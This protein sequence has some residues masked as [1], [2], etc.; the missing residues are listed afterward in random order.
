MNNSQKLF[1]RATYR[2]KAKTACS[3][4]KELLENTG[5][6]DEWYENEKERQ[7]NVLG[8]WCEENDIEIED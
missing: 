2:T 3:R 7:Y 6:L 1:Y 4:Y 5:Y 8:E